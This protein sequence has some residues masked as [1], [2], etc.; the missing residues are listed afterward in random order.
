M[1]IRLL[2]VVLTGSVFSLLTSCKKDNP[3]PILPIVGTWYRGEYSLTVPAAFVR[4]W[5]GTYYNLGESGYTIAIEND[6]T[7]KRSF[8]GYSVQ[9]IVGDVIDAGKWTQDNN[10][11]TLKPTD[12]DKEDLI[13]KPS[14][15]P[16]G[17]E[18]DLE[19]DITDTKMNLSRTVK[20]SLVAD[21]V[22][23]TLTNSKYLKAGNF[24]SV[25][26]KIFYKF[27]KLK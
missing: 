25:D 3:K 5:G 1:K 10:K 12:I 15:W 18:F 13:L 24:Q 16:I 26:V 27:K 20:L 23:D 22:L 2:F 14:Y 19:G 8:T 21:L 11:L 9:G 17:L 4:H 6:K 7:Y